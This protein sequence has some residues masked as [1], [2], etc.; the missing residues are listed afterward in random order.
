MNWVQKKSMLAIETIS[1]EN[2]PCNILTDLWHALHNS[3]NS[4][5]N[6]PVNVC[7]LN[8]I[9]QVDTIKWSIFSKQEFRNA[10]AKY[11]SLSSPGLDHI[12][13]RHLKPLLS[14]DL[15]LEK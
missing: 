11:S 1:Y 5:E 8:E 4:A 9:P 15:C 14:N 6:R 3:Y 10:I 12:S 7:F 2:H 13:W